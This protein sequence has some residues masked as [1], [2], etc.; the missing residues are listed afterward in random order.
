MGG[1]WG[2]GVVLCW[3]GTRGRGR[4]EEF[5]GKEGGG[6]EWRVVGV[7]NFG[8]GGGYS[9]LESFNELTEVCCSLDKMTE[10]RPEWKKLKEHSMRALTLLLV[11]GLVG[12][13]S[14]PLKPP[15]NNRNVVSR[16]VSSSSSLSKTSCSSPPSSSSLSSS[17]TSP[18]PSSPPSITRIGLIC[19]S[20]THI[21][22]INNLNIASGNVGEVYDEDVFMK[23]HST[24][25]PD[26]NI[27]V[28][29]GGEE[30]GEG[31]DYEIAFLENEVSLV[32]S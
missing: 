13:F 14:Q 3:T 19:S 26:I 5:G 12:G 7:R 22:L 23:I 15:R 30:G 6:L 1:G 20:P 17:L 31:T 25:R 11:I 16:S 4:D 2:R 32:N 29:V 18:P 9:S 27:F 21:P 28:N 10:K 24:E 8:K